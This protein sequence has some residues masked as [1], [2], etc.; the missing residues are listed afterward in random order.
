MFFA[1]F[2]AMVV[3]G[4]ILFFILIGIIAGISSSFKDDG[5]KDIVSNSVLVID[6]EEL[7]H[8]QGEKNAFASFSDESSFNPGLYDIK[9]AIEQAKSD[10]NIKGILI[11]INGTPNG[12]ATLQQMR[13]SLLDFKTSN[14]FIYA[15]G[16]VI[17]Q[18]SYYLASVADSIFLNPAGAAEL[19][20]LSTE[21][22][23]FKGTLE[24]LEVEPE[25]YYAGKF[26]SATEPFRADKISD[27]NRQQIV[28]LQSDIWSEFTSAVSMHTK[29][30]PEVINQLTNNGTIQF[31]ADALKYKIVDGLCYWD[32]VEQKLRA[33][34]GRSGDEKIKYISLDDYAKSARAS[35]EMN[36]NRIAVLF[37]E[38][39]I[40]D[41]E[42]NSDYEIASA[43]FIQEIRKL[44]KND[45]IK[46]VVLRVN[47]PGGSALASEVILRELQLLRAKK[48]LIVSMG[49]YAASGG[50]Y[51]S[52]QA[53]SIFALPNTITGS[54]GVFTMLFN[55]G[56]L[57]K[58]KLGVSFDGVKNAPYAD[59]PSVTRKLSDNEAQRMQASVDTI[60]SLFKHRVAVGRHMNEAFV[61]SIAQGRVWT[62]TAAIKIGLVDGLGG[63]DRAIKSAALKANVSSYQVVTYPEPIDKFQ[64]LVHRIKDGN[65]ATSAVKSTIE[66]QIGTD[67]Y[68]IIQQIKDLNKINGKAQMA[69]PFRFKVD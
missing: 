29:T 10:N 23:F 19:K 59:Y 50:Y 8:E 34:T 44:K 6:M 31:P 3:G 26:K 69:M 9:K 39:S 42:K 52:C 36:N 37:A 68:E 41:G 32:E 43:D 5:K 62:G 64:S 7:I 54:I 1:S 57:L 56:Q 66:D 28:A 18:K 60:Y 24:K 61:D 45:K 35:I 12:W 65:I 2:L 67:N 33:R 13:N 46:A 25:I 15:Y 38:G 49:D 27:P 55:G 16:E 30:S 11:K 53:D 51:I 48:P 4:I 58:N 14:K 63:I 40:N 17:P 20:G 22:A 21:L 47:S